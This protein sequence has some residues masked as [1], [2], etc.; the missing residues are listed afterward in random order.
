MQ[1]L[2]TLSNK[3]DALE[4]KLSAEAEGAGSGGGMTDNVVSLLGVGPLD[5]RYRSRMG[6]LKEYFSEYALIKYRLLVEI[7]YFIELVGVLPELADFPTEKFSALR[8]IYQDFGVEDALKVK[9]TEKVTNHD[10]KAVEYLIKDVFDA[11]GLG[12]YKEFIHFALTSQD[13]NNTAIPLSLKDAVDGSYMPAL[14]KFVA[15]VR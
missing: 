8:A 9:A 10:V 7:E 12:Q 14:R 3:V 1:A 13:I 2:S 4:A 5:G 6:S 11:H 15:Q